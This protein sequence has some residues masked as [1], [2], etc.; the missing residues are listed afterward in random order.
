[1]RGGDRGGGRL[2]LRG[3]G[4][5]LRGGGLG[6][7]PWAQCSWLAE[8]LL[9]LI[10]RSSYHGFG[11]GGWRVGMAVRASGA[12]LGSAGTGRG[13]LRGRGCSGFRR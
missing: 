4:G 2:R 13:G 6:G 10:A 9:A 12:F 3:G 7:L 11:G 8:E 1:M 5:A